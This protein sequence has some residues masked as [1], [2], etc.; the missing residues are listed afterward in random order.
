MCWD[1]DGFLTAVLP[2]LGLGLV[3]FCR[4]LD[5]SGLSYRSSGVSQGLPKHLSGFFGYP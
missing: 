2:S 3:V 4:R 5:L 1:A